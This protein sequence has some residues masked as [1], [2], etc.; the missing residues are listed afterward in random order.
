M[1][2]VGSI[3]REEKAVRGMLMVHMGNLWARMNT[4][5]HPHNTPS[6]QQQEAYFRRRSSSAA[7]ATGQVRSMQHKCT[8]ENFNRQNIDRLRFLTVPATNFLTSILI[9]ILLTL[10]N[11]ML[12]K[13]QKLLDKP[14]KNRNRA[15]KAPKRYHAVK[16]SELRVHVEELFTYCNETMTKAF[17]ENERSRS[18]QRSQT[19]RQLSLTTWRYR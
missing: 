19:T 14:F 18:S 12:E 16:N 5:P 17:A 11:P 15:E 1:A 13:V 7:A 8:N 9:D 2:R 4:H 3:S 6:A 10:I